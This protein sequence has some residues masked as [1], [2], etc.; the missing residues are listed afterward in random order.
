MDTTENEP[1]YDGP[2]MKVVSK[3]TADKTAL[4]D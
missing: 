3:P 4:Y 2:V 1:L